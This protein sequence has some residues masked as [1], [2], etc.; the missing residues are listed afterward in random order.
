M[1]DSHYAYAP[2]MNTEY[3]PS[4]IFRNPHLQTTLPTLFRKR[5][6]VRYARER[7]DTPDGDFLDLDWSTTGSRQVCIVLHGLEGCSKSVCVL[8]MVRALNR[9]GIDVLALNYRGCSGVM[10]S[11][12]HF[13]HS[14][15]TSDLHTVV[16]H[17]ERQ[18]SYP[19]IFLIGFSIGGNILLKYLGEQGAEVNKKITRAVAISTPIDL[20]SCTARLSSPGN[21]IYM[22]RFLYS[23]YRKLKQKQKQF[24]GQIDL[25]GFGKIKNFQQFD[26]R[27]TAPSFGYRSA[28]EYWQQN[29]GR[30]FL[31]NI[32]VPTLVLSSRD[33]PF[34]GDDCYMEVDNPV[35][36]TLFSEFGGHVGFISFGQR[37]QY[38]SESTA[39]RYL[40]LLKGS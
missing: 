21:R 2:G 32:Q 26:D 9:Q 36:D 5:Y 8:G 34:L 23:F 39:L 12:P 1:I 38:W 4:P 29:S 37:G 22:Q 10:N 14:G 24:P 6:G 30:H 31:P 13:Y 15:L 28:D 20:A 40:G 19:Q 27:Y 18:C 33:D 11:K 16:T 35:I 17:L 3:R 7:I 25:S